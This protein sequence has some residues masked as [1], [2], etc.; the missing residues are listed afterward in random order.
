MMKLR[1]AFAAKPGP[2]ARATGFAP[3]LASTAVS[4]SMP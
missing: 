3:S 4:L 2:S 1:D